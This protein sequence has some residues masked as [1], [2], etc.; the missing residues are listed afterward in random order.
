MYLSESAFCTK[1][2]VTCTPS[3]FDGNGFEGA[4]WLQALGAGRRMRLT[5]FRVNLSFA[6]SYQSHAGLISAT[7]I[8]SAENQNAE[9]LKA[10][11]TETITWMK[12]HCD[13]LDP[14]IVSFTS[15]FEE[16]CEREFQGLF[17]HILLFL[18]LLGQ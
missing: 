17:G 8:D 7:S 13:G 3:C 5:H 18:N 10:A 15:S 2:I 12:K 4:L 1:K 14:K 9:A 16:Q 6:E 11:K